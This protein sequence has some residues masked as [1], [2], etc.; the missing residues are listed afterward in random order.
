MNLST[1]RNRLSD[2]GDRFEV[3]EGWGEKGV[4]WTESLGVLD[5]NYYI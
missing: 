2:I 1:N 4:G 3:A 5:A